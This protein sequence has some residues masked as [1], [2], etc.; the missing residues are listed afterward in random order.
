MVI[1]TFA[2]QN[3]DIKYEKLISALIPNQVT[4]EFLI[5]FVSDS[6]GV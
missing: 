1:L 6:F 2:S 5:F 3:G 4:T